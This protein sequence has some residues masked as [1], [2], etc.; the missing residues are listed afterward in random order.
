MSSQIIKDYEKSMLKSEVPS[1]RPG[2][3]IKVSVRIIEGDKER[4]QD[5]EGVCIRRR[6]DGLRETMTVRRVNYG[7]GM[8]RIFPIHSPKIDKIQVVRYG[9]VRRAKLYYLRDL[10]GKAARIPELK[11]PDGTPFRVIPIKK[12]KAAAAPAPEE[13]TN[14]TPVAVEAQATPVETNEAAAPEESQAAPENKDEQ[15]S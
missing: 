2:D 3:T 1:F 7:V 5:F 6:G 8:E 14:Q 9:R 15:K 4:L 11:N 12:K 13:V 10:R